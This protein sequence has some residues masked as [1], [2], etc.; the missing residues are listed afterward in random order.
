LIHAGA[1]CLCHSVF[2]VNVFLAGAS[3]GCYAM[4]GAHL[5]NIVMVTAINALLL[6]NSAN[7]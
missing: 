1:G 3:G 6:S 4:I 5:A 2:D 7:N